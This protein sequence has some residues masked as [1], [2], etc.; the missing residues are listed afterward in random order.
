MKLPLHYFG[1]PIL[2]T[3]AQEVV[4]ITP[5]IVQLA[6]DMIEAMI[7]HNGVGLAAPQIGKLIRL[8][9]FRDEVLDEHGEYQL[10][11]PHVVINPILSSPSEEMEEMVEG[12]LSIPN[13]QVPVL[14][15]K[16]IHIRYQNLQG[17]VIEQVLNG[18]LARVNMHEN[19]HLNG[20]LHIDRTSPEERRRVE[21]FLKRLKQ[22]FSK[23]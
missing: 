12:C 17:K 2:R 11:P 8:Y 16:Q 3:K 21:P 13:V 19:D 22:K 9:V 15:P 5:E 1:D 20:V 6:N 7:D 23:K 10:G 18:F 14:R 4:E